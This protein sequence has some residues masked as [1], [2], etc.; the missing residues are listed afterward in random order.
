MKYSKLK[1]EIDIMKLNHKH[2]TDLLKMKHTMTEKELLK[3]CTHEYDDGS[4]AKRFTGTQWDE[5]HNC[6]ICEQSL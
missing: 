2:E 6:E 1:H 4:S 3:Q 5:A